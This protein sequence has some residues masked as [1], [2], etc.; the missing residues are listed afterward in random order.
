MSY[1]GECLKAYRKESSL[2][3]KQVSERIEV[4]DSRL[5][6]IE[7]GDLECPPEIL[8]KLSQLYH[9]PVIKLFLEAGY[10]CEDDLCSYQQVF[11]G[12]SHLDQE[13]FEHVQAEIDFI[14]NRKK[15]VK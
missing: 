14:N 15:G 13:E 7:Q 1:F 6:R 2:S 10:L 11:N 12:V 4:T 3:L 8:R 9:V 5:C